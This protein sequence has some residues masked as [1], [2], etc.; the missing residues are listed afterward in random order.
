[1]RLVLNWTGPIGPGCFPSDLVALEALARPG[2]YLR[3]K[4]YDHGR[5]IGY[6]GQSRNVLIRIDQHLTNA[7]GLL[8]PIR[9]GSGQ[10]RARGD[11]AARL[12]AYNDLESA[13]RLAA[14]DVART[15]FYAASCGDE[16]DADHL[17][18]VEGALKRRIETRIARS[19]GA[20][21]CDNLQGIAVP[22]EAIEMA[23]DNVLDAL[24]PADQAVVADL[25]G[26]EPIE[27][28]AMLA[29]AGDHG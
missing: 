20:L 29:E 11:F 25:V 19:A 21:A 16:F 10:V 3:V 2:V 14:E 18:L 5:T 13:V 15:R 9:D 8:Y 17:T 6:V 1:M 7:L 4:R 23:I 22:A 24:A 28:A 26:R 12:A 27:I